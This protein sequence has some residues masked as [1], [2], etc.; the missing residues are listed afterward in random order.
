MRLLTFFAIFLTL[1]CVLSTSNA[2]ADEQPTDDDAPTAPTPLPADP[3][4]PQTIVY[5]G[6]DTTD[7][8]GD[9]RFC[10]TPPQE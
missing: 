3:A 7:E 10:G 1:L 9:P 4:D 2:L 5:D 6:T 8:H